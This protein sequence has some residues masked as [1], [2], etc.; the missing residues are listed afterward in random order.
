MPR[1]REFHDATAA[2]AL[3][4]HTETVETRCE[5][6]SRRRSLERFPWGSGNLRADGTLASRLVFSHALYR[7]TLYEHLSATRRARLHVA[8]ASRLDRRGFGERGT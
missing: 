3:S 6:S 5:P 4:Q 2:A 8:I 1:A 7:A